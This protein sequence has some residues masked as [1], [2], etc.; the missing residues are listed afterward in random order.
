MASALERQDPAV[1]AAVVGEERRLREHI[2]LI[3]SENYPSA[4]VLEANGSV[5][6]QKYAEGYPKYRFYQG[7]RWVDEVEDLARRRARRLFRAGRANVQPHSGSAA[8]MAVYFAALEPGDTVLALDLA[9]G[10]HLT[11]GD[12]SNFSA[13]LYNFVHYGVDPQ[14]ERIDF[15]QVA[16]LAREHPPK[17]IVTGATA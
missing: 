2:Q 15:D 17:M 9:S 13:K 4:A 1:Y 10:G 8:N 12:P 14:T 16:R 11:H 6:T 3:P 7:C 5:M